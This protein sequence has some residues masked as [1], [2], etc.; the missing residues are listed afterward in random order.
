MALPCHEFCVLDSPSFVAM[1][2]WKEST[3][4]RPI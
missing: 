1:L 3:T 2:C 4:R